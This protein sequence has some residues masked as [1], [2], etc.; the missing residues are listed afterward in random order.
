MSVGRPAERR[1]REPAAHH[2]AERGEVRRHSVVVL[3]PAVPH[4]EPG[5]HLVEQ[6]HGSAV[7]AQRPEPFQESGLGRHDA[8]V[9]RDRLDRDDRDLA[10]ALG[11]DRSHGVQVVEGHRERVARGTLGDTR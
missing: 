7:V 4:P 3:R 5:D 1:A 8:H 2:L 11:H 10:T 6:Q 9:G